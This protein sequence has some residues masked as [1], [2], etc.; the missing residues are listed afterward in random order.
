[1][2]CLGDVVAAL[3]DGELDHAARERAQ[4]HLAHCTPCRTE[5]DA[6]RRLKARLTG[7]STGEVA[8]SDALTARLLG[9]RPDPAPSPAAEPQAAAA[10]PQAAPAGTTVGWRVQP[11]PQTGPRPARP[12]ANRAATAGLGAERRR[13]RSLRRSAAVGSALAVL[14]AA[15]VLGG[16]QPSTPTTPVDP[17]ADAFVADFVTTTTG[18]TTT[19]TTTTGT[20]TTGITTGAGSST[21]GVAGGGRSQR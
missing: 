17:G 1:M 11:R 9:L 20:T 16:P 3:V 7:T 13:R 14:G 5:V 19:G 21:A 12:G 6:Q 15:L 4:R 2:S 18:T 8:P 10:E